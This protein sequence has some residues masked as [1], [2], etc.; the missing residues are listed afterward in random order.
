[1]KI[2]K[3]EARKCERR[4]WM[5]EV[6]RQSFYENG[7]AA[8]TMS[9]IAAKLGG[10]KG[11]LWSYFP[12]K[13]ALFTAVID[14]ATTEFMRQLSEVLE[15]HEDVRSTLERLCLH[16]VTKVTA[17]MSI[18]L[19]RLVNGEGGRFPELGRI[20]YERGPKNVKALIGEYFEQCMED[21]SMRRADPLLA[22]NHLLG[23]CMM[24]THQKLLLNV[25]DEPAVEEL[26]AEAAAAVD[27][28]VRAYGTENL[29]ASP[30]PSAQQLRHE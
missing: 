6:A 29:A 3:R 17:P 9:E 27:A 1:M 19:H 20:F 11:T 23:L 26:K 7:Y 5:L 15:L 14:D 10:S 8:T 4:A 2:S 22:A 25:I 30:E 28:F 18:G 21:G 24:G 12:S 13:E 16:F